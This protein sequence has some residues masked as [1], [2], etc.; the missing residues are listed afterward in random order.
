MKK[1]LFIV[2]AATLLLAGCEKENGTVTKAP[3][4][5]I[6]KAFAEPNTKADL[7]GNFQ[8]VWHNTDEVGIVVTSYYINDGNESIAWYGNAKCTTTDDNV[9]DATFKSTFVPQEETL[10]HAWNIA[11]FYPWQ[12][13]GSDNNNFFATSAPEVYNGVMY[14]KLP[15]GYYNYT[16]GQSQLPMLANMTGDNLNPT[17]MHF[18]HVGAAVKVSLKS[19]PAGTHSI[20]MTVDDTQIWGDCDPIAPAAAGTASISFTGDNAKP[21]NNTVWLNFDALTTATDM[22][23][24]FPVPALT[25]PK[26]S[27][28]MYNNN[29]VMIWKKSLKAQTVSITR[30]QILDIANPNAIVPLTTNTVTV[31]VISYLVNELGA[32]GYQIHCW[33]GND[34]AEDIDLV[35]TGNTVTKDVGYWSEAQTFHLYTAEIPVDKFNYKVRNGGRWFGDNGHL[36]KPNAYIFNYSGD[37]VLYE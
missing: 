25:T 20:G 6:L 35:A 33:D 13:T 34:V 27:F 15:E 17:E 12:G 9:T 1:V 10:Y 11:A 7:N 8:T 30:G 2:A 22:E 32:E 3:Q 14:F 21:K 23:F 24:I 18:K 19:V 26:L 36:K 37:K 28:R 4:E 29:D 16:S 5:I 31:G